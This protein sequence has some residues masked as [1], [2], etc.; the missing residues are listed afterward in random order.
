MGYSGRDESGKSQFLVFL[1]EGR[2]WVFGDRKTTVRNIGHSLS[3]MGKSDMPH[4][5]LLMLAV[6]ARARQTPRQ[7]ISPARPQPVKL[8][9]MA[10]S[11]RRALV[12]PLSSVYAHSPPTSVRLSYSV[13]LKPSSRSVL[14]MDSPE[15]PESVVVSYCHVTLES[16]RRAKTGG[17]P[18]VPAPMT[19]TVCCAILALAIV[20]SEVASGFRRSGM[21]GM[22][23]VRCSGS[24]DG[25]VVEE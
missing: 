12:I 21:S 5:Y 13:T 23:M 1:R 25:H 7:S 17:M 8:Q 4:V 20:V 24:D 22:Q 6:V 9:Y 10:H 14:S 3:G 19:A 18:Y 2:G 11:H 16:P 15:E